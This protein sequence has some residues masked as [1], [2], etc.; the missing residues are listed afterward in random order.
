MFGWGKNK[1]ANAQPQAQP[2]LQKAPTQCPNCNEMVSDDIV[3]MQRGTDYNREV[4]WA[5]CWKCFSKPFAEFKARGQA[6]I[7][8]ETRLAALEA[9]TVARITALEETLYGD[10]SFEDKEEWKKNE[11][12]D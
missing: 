1:E 6:L 2:P 9:D 12:G 5:A 10:D 7:D 4:L 3:V 8:L 11:Q